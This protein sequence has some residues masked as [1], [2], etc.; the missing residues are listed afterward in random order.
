MT[1]G[2]F[3]DTFPR[4]GTS[5]NASYRCENKFLQYDWNGFRVSRPKEKR[6]VG[7]AELCRSRITPLQCSII[8]PVVVCHHQREDDAKF[9][10]FSKIAE[11]GPS[12]ASR[13]SQTFPEVHTTFLYHAAIQNR[14]EAILWD[15]EHSWTG[16]V[17]RS[18]A[19][20]CFRI[21]EF[22]RT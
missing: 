10:E 16:N 12:R 13:L 14:G 17:G 18:R 1:Q 8:F 4:S 2:I 6:G 15:S 22:S 20:R 9:L 21:V 3:L 19:A 7:T 5:G 11:D